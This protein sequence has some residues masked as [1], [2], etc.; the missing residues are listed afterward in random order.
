MARLNTREPGTPVTQSQRDAPDSGQ[1]VKREKK[2]PQ[3]LLVVSGLSGGGKSTALHAL[4]DLGYYCVDNLP[5][6][7]LPGFFEQIRTD[8]KLYAR[9]ALGI[10]ARSRGSDQQ[11]LPEQLDQLAHSGLSH[12]L[13][14]LTAD[15]RTI[16]KRFSETRR[17]HPLTFDQHALPAAIDREKAL[18][19]PLQQKA[20]WVIDTSEINIHQLRQQVWKYVGSE[21]STMTI[22]LESFAFKR[23]LPQDLDFVFDARHCPNPHWIDDLRGLSGL[24]KPV[25]E[26]LEDQEQVGEFRQDI[27]HFLARWLPDIRE[28]Q[29]SYLTIGIGC[30]G[31]KHRSVYLSECIAEELRKDFEP[32]VVYHR[33][34]QNP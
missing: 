23:G 1:P 6:A 21:A 25:R 33:E 11:R 10:D 18:L 22:V 34:L 3:Q 17:R 20:D 31:G 19:E 13:L 8:P 32:I 24:D 4:E 14:F 16:I 15:T 27:L 2:A 28:S 7:L 26:W 9:V 30:T 12:R 5:A 29:R